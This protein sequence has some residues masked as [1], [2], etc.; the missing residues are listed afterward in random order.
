MEL[1]ILTALVVK[2]QDSAMKNNV[3]ILALNVILEMIMIRN[4]LIVTHIV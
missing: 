3:L 2:P 1:L 4:V